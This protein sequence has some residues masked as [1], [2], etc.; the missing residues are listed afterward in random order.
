MMDQHEWREF[1][2]S[3]NRMIAGLRVVVLA[4]AVVGAALVLWAVLA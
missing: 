3:M 2:R 4:A 1:C